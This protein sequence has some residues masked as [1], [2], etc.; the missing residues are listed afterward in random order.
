VAA[1]VYAFHVLK[2]G[3]V[4]HILIWDTSWTVFALYFAT[5]LFAR[6]SW[7]DASG[8]AVCI[9]LQIAGSLYPLLAAIV[10]A[11]PFLGWLIVRFRL[12]EVRLLQ[13]AALAA[14]VAVAFGLFLAPYLRANES[15]ELAEVAFQVYRPL[16]YLLPGGSG[17]SGWVIVLLVAVGLAMRGRFAFRGTGGDPRVALVIGGLL[18]LGF[19]V[20]GGGD[21]GQATVPV[22]SGEAPPPGFPNLYIALK[23]LI[24]GFEVGRG[25]GAM[26]GGVHLAL[27]ALAGIGAAALLRALPAR[28]VLAGSAALVLLAATDTLRPAALGLTPRVD[29]RLIALG[30]HE[31]SLALFD[32]LEERGDEGPLLEYPVKH[33]NLYRASMG[34]LL[35]SYHH[36]QTSY[37]YNSVFPDTIRAVEAKSEQLPS[38]DAIEA[39]YAL[40]F[41]TLV[42]HHVEGQLFAD[43][44]RDRFAA[45]AS[46]PGASRLRRLAGNESLTAYRML[47]Q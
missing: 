10:I 37:C 23:E 26:Y 11:I 7:R 43:A 33:A 46:G 29:Y 36:R 14:T 6:G 35:S 40:G 13:L 9:L 16:S 8:L 17:F 47:A 42:V 28:F 22:L 15:G 45:Y 25:P 5:R 4:I 30:P 24:P 39:L 21:P 2:L 3:D 18:V 38:P 1:L 27:C 19:S 20:V 34:V 32:E 31:D 44:H 12:R 41:R